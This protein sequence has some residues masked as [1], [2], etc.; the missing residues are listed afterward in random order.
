[1]SRKISLDDYQ[2][3][4]SCLKLLNKTEGTTLIEKGRKPNHY[5]ILI[6]GSLSYYIDSE[7]SNEQVCVGTAEPGHLIY[8]EVFMTPK[9]VSFTI[10]CDTNC[11]F[12]TFG[13]EIFTKS[14]KKTLIREADLL[15][16]F[17]NRTTL[18]DGLGTLNIRKYLAY[19]IPKTYKYN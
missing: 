4:I 19:F 3:L 5:L 11:S 7:A 15:V 12:L 18:F 9:F 13:E 2:E 16:D 1:M 10:K 6:E 17:L 14:I 8:P